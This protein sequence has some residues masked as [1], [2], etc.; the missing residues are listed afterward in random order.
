MRTNILESKLVFYLV[1]AICFLSLV[2]D[3]AAREF[4]FVFLFIAM[5]FF[6]DMYIDNRT[7]LLS[8]AFITSNILLLKLRFNRLK[9]YFLYFQNKP[10]N[11]GN[12][13][14]SD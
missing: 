1:C 8:I 10:G 6:L 11:D 9:Y 7:L 2:A 5:V 14:I 12:H 3:I 13:V 4:L